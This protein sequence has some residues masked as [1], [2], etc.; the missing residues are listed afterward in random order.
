MKRSP[1]I[2][3]FL[4]VFVDVLGLTIIVPLL[5]I[6]AETL[7][8]SA[9]VV[10]LLISVYGLCQ[11][12]AG[13]ILGQISDRIG[14]KPLLIVSQ[15]GT[16]V[17]FLILAFSR[18]L[19]VIFLSRIIDGLTA[20]NISVAQAYISDVTR[21]ENRA[22]AFGLIGIAFGLGFLIG[23]AISGFLARYG[24]RVPIFAAAGLSALSVIT[25]WAILPANPPRTEEDL[26]ELAA[27][28]K[29]ERDLRHP[30]KILMGS[31]FRP[32]LGPVLWQFFAFTFTFSLFISGFPLFAE[33]RFLA[34]GRPFGVQEIGYVLAFMGLIG[35]L[36][37]GGLVGRL[38]KRFGEG[39][40]V[41]AGF[42]AMGLSELLLARISSIPMLLLAIVG[43]AFGSSVVRPALTS[44]VT[45][46]V[47]RHEQGMA[48]GLTQGLMSVSQIVAPMV[49]GAL[50]S[51][52]HLQ[53]WALAAALFC[54]I[55]TALAAF[56]HG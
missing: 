7:G 9:F 29:T 56:R 31:L 28:S 15:L 5:P 40:L 18:T 17:G 10:G 11:L 1:L 8:A 37:Q 24:H 53:L 42:V 2:P 16:F 23:P 26:A 49:G 21:K 27:H 50:I 54:L 48:I 41:V 22:H 39:R 3:I 4:I 6:Y 32:N 47:P 20:G 43:L 52:S 55:G 44:L 45:F 19:P 25:T 36:I 34:H 12:I 13:P 51:G 35:I 38:V 33:R 46:L 14:R 30:I